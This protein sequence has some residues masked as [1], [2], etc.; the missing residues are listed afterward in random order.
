MKPTASAALAALFALGA[1]AAQ[2]FDLAILHIN[3]FHSRIESINRFDSTCSAE[4][5]G[6]GACFGGVARLK[7]ALDARRAALAAEGAEVLTLDAGDQFQG[8]LFYTLHGGAVVAEFL[9][10]FGFDAMALGNHEFDNGPAGLAGLLDGARMPVLSANLDAASEPLAAGRVAPYAVIER[11]GRRI[12]V[13]GVTTTETAEI[14]SPGPTLR[15][16]DEIAA[17][18]AA[19]AELEAQGVTMIVALTHVGLDRDRE[20]AAQVAGLD[21]VVGGHSHTLM[22]TMEGAAAP[23]PLMVAGPDGTQVPVVQAYAYGKYLGELR[24][25]FDDAGRVTSAGGA[26]VL[27]DAAFAP[28]AG[29]AARVAEL[30]A[31][32]EALRSEVVAE[33]A[34]PIGADRALCRSRECEMGVLV[35]EAMLARARPL[36]A[37]LAIQNGGGLR[38]GIDGGPITRGEVLTVLPFQNTLATFGLPGADV[39]AA[40]ENGVS[41]LAEGGGRFPQVAGLRYTL[42]PDAPVGSRISAVEVETAAGWAPIEPARVYGVATNNF[43]RKGGDGYRMFAEK[44]VDPYDFGPNLEDVVIDHLRA[45]SPYAPRLAGRIAVAAAAPAP[46]AVPAPVPAAA[47]AP[48]PAAP[49]GHRVARGESLWVIAR[50]ELGDA[51]RWPEIAAANGLSAPW[52]IFPDQTLT[53]PR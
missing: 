27:I 37:E 19:V 45:N 52:L 34:A 1:G 53:L 14:A 2:A 23:Y 15:F 48:A 16:G 8:S 28:D 22:G 33:A 38:A 44:A 11:E 18:R 40:L 17:L 13:V 26:P 43:M 9:N 21:A 39:V 6:K 42:T 5:E 32:I 36:G 50:S 51:T 30:A 49:A 25:T 4:D 47:P 20:I 46:A 24:L 12:G 35:A 31:P 3:D 7:T 10:A 41:Q 29:V